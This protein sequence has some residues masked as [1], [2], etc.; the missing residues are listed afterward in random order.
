MDRRRNA[1]DPPSKRRP[2]HPTVCTGD[3]IGLYKI[4]MDKTCRIRRRIDTK[5]AESHFFKKLKYYNL[6][7]D[8]PSWQDKNLSTHKPRKEG[9]KPI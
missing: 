3:Q 1:D 5:Y 2:G 6:A 7:K 8:K 9:D 4:S